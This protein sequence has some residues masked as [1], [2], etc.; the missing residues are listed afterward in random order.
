[1]ISLVVYPRLLELGYAKDVYKLD[2]AALY[3]KIE[4]THGIFPNLDISGVM[5]GIPLM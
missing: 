4:I 2:F 5:E 1:V 3:P